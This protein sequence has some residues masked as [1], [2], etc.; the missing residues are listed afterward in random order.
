MSDD[1]ATVCPVCSHEWPLTNVNAEFYQCPQCGEIWDACD[2]E[3]R[4]NL[5]RNGDGS[6]E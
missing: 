4:L 6:G 2:S 5:Q 3:D 1:D